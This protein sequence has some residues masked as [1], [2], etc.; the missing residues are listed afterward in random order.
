LSQKK[1]N[2]I[3]RS[4]DCDLIIDHPSVSRRHAMLERSSDGRL[5]LQDSASKNGTF[6]H[7]SSQWI[8]ADRISLCRDDVIRLG[9]HEL[10]P[11]KFLSLFGADNRVW[12]PLLSE[13]STT[14]GTSS[15]QVDGSEETKISK[16]RRNPV[17]GQ[18]E[19]NHS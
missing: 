9:D 10:L 3:G 2:I 5:Y 14:A 6:L 8:R 19:E 11:D 18:I 17:T 16:P 12:L 1:I 15:S 13:H 4:A 7:R